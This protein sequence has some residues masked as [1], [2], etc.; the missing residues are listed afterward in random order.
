MLPPRAI[1]L[2]MK[3]HIL[4]VDDEAQIREML[5]EVL[6]TAGYRVSGASTGEEA[7]NIIRRDPPNLIITD[8]QLEESDGFDVIE[9]V[10]A[11]A[12]KTPV[13]LLTGV[14]FDPAV[15]QGPVGNK[16]AAYVE[17][18]EPLER[19][20]QAVRKQLAP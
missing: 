6:T 10:K 12:P 4:T 1:L 16:I 20:L 9:Q 15:M 5:R 3:Q 8:L 11:L 19:V 17:K 14:L 7:L 18:T 13:I 2:S